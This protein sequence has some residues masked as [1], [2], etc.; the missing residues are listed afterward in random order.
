M[1]AI[2]EYNLK[3]L[4]R[5]ADQHESRRK[6][7][8][9]REQPV[10]MQQ[11]VNAL[12]PGT[13][14][15]PYKHKSP[16]QATLFTILSGKVAIMRFSDI[17]VIEQVCILD[18]VGSVKVVNVPSNTYHTILPMQPSAILQV[19]QGPCDPKTHTQTAPWAPAEHHTKA[20]DYL[21]YLASIVDN[22]G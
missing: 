17:G 22:W 20:G 6:S 9:F 12:I 7:F 21:W 3:A 15:P 4:I 10:S 1:Q 14:I 18:E 16:N 2:T 19:V 11:M 13:Y 8:Q 5:K